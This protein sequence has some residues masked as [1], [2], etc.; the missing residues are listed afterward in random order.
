MSQITTHVLDTSQGSPARHISVKLFKQWTDPQKES[1][2]DTADNHADNYADNTFCTSDPQWTLLAEGRT[3]EDGRI[4]DLL[5]ADKKL[6]SGNYR[7]L[8]DTQPY[9][10]K[11]GTTHFYPWIDIIFT[12]DDSGSHYHVPVLLSP[13]GYSTYRGS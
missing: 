12:L 5:P 9:F 4:T 10:L 11:T 2:I 7:L 13:F 6:P 3:N 1:P 8:F